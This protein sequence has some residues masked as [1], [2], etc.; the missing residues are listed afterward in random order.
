MR[1]LNSYLFLAGLT[2]LLL[3]SCQNEESLI[4]ENFLD[5][6]DHEVFILEQEEINII[7]LSTIEDS[8]T[9]QSSINLLGSYL[10]PYFGLTNASFCFQ[11]TLPNNEMSFNASSINNIELHLPYNNFYGDS[12]A[13]FNINVS[14]LTES[15]NNNDSLNV[16]SNNEFSS[17]LITTLNDVELSLISDSAALKVPLPTNF[18]LA[19][20]LNLSN[21]SL[22]NTESFTESFYGFKITVEPIMSMNG[23][24]VYFDLSS[25][26]S[27]LNITYINSENIEQSVSFPTG[28]VKLNNFMHD[29]TNTMIETTDSL[30]FIQSMGG[31]FAE[32]DF[33]FLEN[34]QDSGYIVNN[35]ELSLSIFEENNFFQKPERITLIENNNNNLL[36]IEGLTGGFLD[37]D[38]QK[39]TFNMTQHIQKILTEDHNSKCRIYTYSRTSNADRVIINNTL[40]HPIELKLV[41]IK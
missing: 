33:S 17:D 8:V 18:G 11:I 6:G 5:N 1:L 19:E 4:G 14:K 16:F 29:Y 30:L 27:A 15:I 40:E 26:N 22:A 12:L 2:L 13:K 35:A 39:Y 41:L 23:A 3:L 36:P 9:A 20:I 28:G 7:A 10:D 24:I 21:T 31:T 32:L 25:E 34:L 37:E 38:N